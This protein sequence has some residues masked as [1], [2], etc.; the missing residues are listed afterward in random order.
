MGT[1]SSHHECDT[2]YEVEM[3]WAE[4][5]QLQAYVHRMMQE[6]RTVVEQTLDKEE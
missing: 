2:A 1:C 5:E 3:C 4:V 6:Y